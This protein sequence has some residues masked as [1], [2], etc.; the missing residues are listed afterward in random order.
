MA[1]GGGGREGV[2]ALHVGARA[3]WRGSAYPQHVVESF[4]VGFAVDPRTPW[5]ELSEALRCLVLDGPPDGEALEIPVSRGLMDK[6][7][8]RGFE[9]VV[10]ILERNYEQEAGGRRGRT[11]EKFM[12]D[13]RCRACGGKRLRPGSLAVLI[14]SRS[15]A[16]FTVLTIDQPLAA[17]GQM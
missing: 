16:D 11:I 8:G 1:D 10:P 13:S 17:V 3:P 12:R 5:G 2:Q 4:C 6:R 14:H 7:L 15:I 9:G